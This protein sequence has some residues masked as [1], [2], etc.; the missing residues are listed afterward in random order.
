M[1]YPNNRIKTGPSWTEVVLGAIL[2]F[3]LGVILSA[4]LLV[5]KPVQSVKDLPKE[6]DRKAD[7]VYY[8]E[9]S[10]DTTKGGKW[11]QKQ[12][13]F[14]AGTTISVTEDELNAAFGGAVAKPPT[15]PKPGAKPEPAAAPANGEMLS[16]AA[17]NFRIRNGVFQIGVPV[18]VSVLGFNQTVIMQARGSFAKKGDRFVF[19]PS[20]LYLGSC[21][22]SRL[23]AA[24][25]MVLKKFLWKQPAPDEL[26]AAWQ[27]LTDVSIDGNTLKLAMQ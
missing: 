20:E 24:E 3:V 25:G 8:L 13:S 17:P 5:L 12:Q 15:P 19:V 18:S 6:A 26:V 10:R 4:V 9:G 7:V 16:S 14:V 27:K 1:S 21:P 11:Q 2:S 22:L 23:P